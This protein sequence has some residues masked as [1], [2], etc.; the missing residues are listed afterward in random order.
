MTFRKLVVKMLSLGG[1][2]A[3]IFSGGTWWVSAQSANLAMDRPT[4]HHVE[5][6]NHLSGQLNSS[7]AILSSVSALCV[8]IALIVDD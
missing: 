6:I 5:D 3:A 2:L 8:A 1:A 7:A 4:S